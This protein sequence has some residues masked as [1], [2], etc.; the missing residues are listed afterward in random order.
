MNNKSNQDST[1]TKPDNQKH[2]KK[3]LDLLQKITELAN[4][5]TELLNDLKRTRADFENFR[6]QVDYQK[7]Q[8]KSITT[9]STIAKFLPLLDDIDLAIT[10]HPD[11]LDPIKKSLEK[12]LSQLNLAKINSN[13][14]TEFNPSLHEAISMDGGSG[15]KE[16]VSSTLRPGYL[17]NNQVIRPAMVKVKLV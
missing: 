10:A 9:E 8:I 12:T 3:D 2:S 13:P 17:Y 16:V 1:N 6:K 5:N 15:E 14:D 7:D 11:Q 4:Q